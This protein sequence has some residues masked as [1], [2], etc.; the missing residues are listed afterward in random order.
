MKHINVR[1]LILLAFFADIGFVSKRI[2]APFANVLTDFLRV[3][4]GIGTAFSLMFLVIGACMIRRKGAA[5]VMGLVQCILAMSL[6]LTG[7]MGM[8]SPVGY[9]LPG[10]IIDI[11]IALCTRC[12]AGIPVTMITANAAG[13]VM[14]ALTA[15]FIVF[16]LHGAVLALYLLIGLISGGICGLIAAVIHRRIRPLYRNT[17]DHSVQKEKGRIV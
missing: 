1:D 14:A 12:N 5:A 8:M 15:N 11:T 10:I 2:I 17:E 9:I 13:S 3:P 7:A 6:G 16:R 4:G